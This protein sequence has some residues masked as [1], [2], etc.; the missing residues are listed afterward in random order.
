MTLVETGNTENGFTEILQA[1]Q[2]A[3]EKFVTRGAYSLL[4]GL[5]NK[6]ED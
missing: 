3:K 4:M 1:D 5:K 6:S 2:L